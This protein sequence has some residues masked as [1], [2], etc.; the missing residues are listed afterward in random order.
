MT[1]YEASILRWMLKCAQEWEGSVTGS[2]GHAEFV[3]ALKDAKAL[4]RKLTK[5]KKRKK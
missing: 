4:V 1:Q 5:S 2:S 3:S